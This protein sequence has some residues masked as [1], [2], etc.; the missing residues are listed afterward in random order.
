MMK[1]WIS[2]MIASL[3]LAWAGEF[4][5]AVKEG[6]WDLNLRFRFEFVDLEGQDKQA[7]AS[8]LRTRLGYTTAEFYE[9]KLH[10]DFENTTVIGPERYNST[11]NGMTDRPVVADPEDTEVNQVYLA[12]MGWQDQVVTLGRQRIIMDDARFIGNVGWRQNEQTYDAL[13]WQVKK[14]RHTINVTYIDN[15]NR[16][17]G[18]HHPNSVNSDLRSNSFFGHYQ[19]GLGKAG[20]LS[21]FAHFLEFENASAISHQNLGFRWAGKVELDG[22]GLQHALSYVKQSDYNATLVIDGETLDREFDAD[23]VHFELGPAWENFS[24]LLA[25][26]LLSSDGG[27]Y[28][29]ATPLATLHAHNGW[30][31]IFLATPGNGLEDIFA[32]AAGSFGRWKMLGIYHIFSSDE[33]SFDFGT[34]LDLQATTKITEF[35]NLGLKAA[36]YDADT[37]S[38]DTTKVWVTVDCKW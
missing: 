31:D 3:N 4:S 2:L 14:D 35:M 24:F 27:A 10:V 26:E 20:N 22:W 34:E 19:V 17:F 21:A 9:F 36:L 16:I 6:K 1:I 28:G 15:V 12:Y 30:A 29:F 37:Y 38:R 33:G 13:R 32:K 11:S 25:Y 23:Y 8:T 7:Y 5:N 18:E